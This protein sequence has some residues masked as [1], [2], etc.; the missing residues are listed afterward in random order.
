MVKD[1]PYGSSTYYSGITPVKPYVDNPEDYVFKGWMPSPDNITGETNCVALFKF[2]G[3]LFGKLGKTDEEDYGYG[4]VNNPNWDEINAYWNVI[5]SD[6]ESY[7]NGSLSENNFFAKYPIGGRMLVPIN[8]SDGFKIADL[9]IIGHNHDNLADESGKAPLTFFCLDLP[10]IQKPMNVNST[11]EGGW[12]L[13]YMRSFTNGE[14]FN[15]LPNELQN[16]IVDVLK[17][18]DGGS[19]NKTFINSCC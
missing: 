12:E 4:S 14:L 15:A 10:T 17:I 3:Y 13:S 18:S 8:L 19:N 6:I 5:G 2:V 16:L 7:K 9:E 1:V 11:N